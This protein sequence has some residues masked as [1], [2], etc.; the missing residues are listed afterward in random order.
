VYCITGAQGVSRP[1]AVED[2]RDRLR[3]ELEAMGAR[4]PRI[5]LGT[6]AD[7]YPSVEA[8]LGI[9][10]VVLDE[11]ILLGWHVRIITKGTTVRRDIDLLTR[12]DTQVVVS[13]TTPD[14]D[15]LAHLEPGAPTPT[16]RL[17]VVRE[18]RAA[19]VPRGARAVRRAR[20][21]ALA[22]APHR[23]RSRQPP[24]GDAADRHVASR[25]AARGPA[26]LTVLASADRAGVGASQRIG[27]SPPGRTRGVLSRCCAG[28]W[29]GR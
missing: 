4:Q 10:R 8:D 27:A 19:G 6:V 28:R 23:P 22:P 14:D 16:E 20:L 26:M 1:R 24:P 12:G 15:A 18:L 25:P 11:L 17:E 7:A 29:P 9:T 5:G 3:R 13:V 21:G 2:V